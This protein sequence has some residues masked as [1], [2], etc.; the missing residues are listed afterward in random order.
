MIKK[1]LLGQ[2]NLPTTFWK[3]YILGVIFLVILTNTRFYL[4]AVAFLVFFI[5]IS[6]VGIWK[7]S[8]FYIE[9]NKNKKSILWGYA[10]RTWVILTIIMMWKGFFFNTE[11][12]QKMGFNEGE[13]VLT[14]VA[15]GGTED[16]VSLFCP[17]YRPN[18][19][20]ENKFDEIKKQED[21][22]KIINEVIKDKK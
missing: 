22:K 11:K 17:F 12:F 2:Y 6:L 7:S 16:M 8:G 20:V 3:I 5:F 9:K 21:I 10:A 14:A 15:K 19:S 4:D 13:S 1:Y 18:Q